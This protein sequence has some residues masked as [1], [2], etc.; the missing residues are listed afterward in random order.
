MLK[1]KIVVLFIIAFLL[2]S[3]VADAARPALAFAKGS[4]AKNQSEGGG[5]EE[6]EAAVVE[7]GCEGVGEKECL[8][9]RTLAA[10]T[11]YIYTQSYKP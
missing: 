3:L 8:A 7:E 9:T 11:D 10:N 6:A 2:C 5:A 4:V 1:V